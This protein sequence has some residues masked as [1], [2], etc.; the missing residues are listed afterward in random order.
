MLG[1]NSSETNEPQSIINTHSIN[2]KN[3]NGKSQE[4]TFEFVWM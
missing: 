4:Q 2:I 3:D 1:V